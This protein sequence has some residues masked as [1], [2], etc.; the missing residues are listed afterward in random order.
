ME[1]EMARLR[2]SLDPET[3]RGEGGEARKGGRGEADYNVGEGGG[4]DG[5][6]VGEGGGG[7]GGIQHFWNHMAASPLNSRHRPGC[8][9]ARHRSSNLR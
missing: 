1:E 7:E 6:V 8:R 5:R 4:G 3:R 9:R 2:P